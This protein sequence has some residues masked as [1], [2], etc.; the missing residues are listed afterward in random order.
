MRAF[1]IISITI[2]FSLCL[3][4]GG[5]VLGVSYQNTKIDTYRI[6]S[7]RDLINGLDLIAKELEPI[8]PNTAII[9]YAVAGSILSDD[10]ERLAIFMQ[11]YSEIRKDEISKGNQ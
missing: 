10:T 3:I 7:D 6:T 2:I 4:S 1:K 8:R 5:F 11:K 9:L